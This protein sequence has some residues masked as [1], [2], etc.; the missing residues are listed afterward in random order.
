MH[1]CMDNECSCIKII[2]YFKH[3]YFNK[4]ALVLDFEMICNSICV[5]SYPSLV[6]VFMFLSFLCHVV[7][8]SCIRIHVSY[9]SG[10]LYII[11]K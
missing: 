8:K 6:F 9:L 5:M 1:I 3:V 7:S 4:C 11:Y 2:L 10:M